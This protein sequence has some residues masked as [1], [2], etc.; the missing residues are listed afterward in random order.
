MDRSPWSLAAR[1]ASSPR[2]SARSGTTLAREY[3]WTPNSIWRSSRARSLSVTSSDRRL[4]T[5][6]ISSRCRA[7]D[8]RCMTGPYC[9]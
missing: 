2:E 8:D 9:A 5:R 3:T 7:E 1:W 6:R 4:V